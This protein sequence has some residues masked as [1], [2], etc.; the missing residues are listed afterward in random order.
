MASIPKMDQ[1]LRDVGELF[2]YGR[3]FPDIANTISDVINRGTPLLRI[4]RDQVVASSAG[5]FIVEYQ[6]SDGMV[7]ILTAARR[8]IARDRQLEQS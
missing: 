6:L 5:D 2:D 7:A 8:C 4:N 1:A 3:E